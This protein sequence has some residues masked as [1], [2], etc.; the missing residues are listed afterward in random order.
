[1][2]LVTFGVQLFMYAT[3]VIYPLNAAPDSIE[4]IIRLNP[5]S[6]IIEGL[7][8]AILGRGDFEPGSLLYSAGVILGMTFI[9]ILIFNKTE[10]NFID[11]V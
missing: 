1:V 10:K 8:L 9:G 5:L 11:T 2:F 7:R 6:S 3:P 4:S